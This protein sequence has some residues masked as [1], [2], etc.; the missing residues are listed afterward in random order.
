MSDA[1]PLKVPPPP[2]P[3]HRRAPLPGHQPK[4]AAEDPQAAQR[5]KAIL[6]N[7]SYREADQDVEFLNRYEVRGLR[8][9]LDYLKAEL[10]LEYSSI[11][12]AIVVFGG[13]RIRETAAAQREIDAL[14]A[15]R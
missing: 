8:L 4:S 7:A 5:V 13:T 15:A 11:R 6:E 3:Y 14:E 2:H 12:E 9:Q 10:L 1:K